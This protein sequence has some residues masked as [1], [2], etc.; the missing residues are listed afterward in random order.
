MAQG[1]KTP[2]KIKALNGTLDKRFTLT[3]EMKP[4]ALNDVEEKPFGLVNDFAQKEWLKVTGILKGLGMLHECDTS[5]L[6]AYCNEIGVYFDC[7]DKVRTVG[8]VE[9][10]KANGMIIRNEMRIGNQCLANAIK[11]ADKFGFNPAARTKID[12]GKKEEN[13][14]FDDITN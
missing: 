1:K 4:P 13:D 8:Y 5:L 3:N 14:I 6:L 2:T 7:M 12:M 10:S 9:K 11:L